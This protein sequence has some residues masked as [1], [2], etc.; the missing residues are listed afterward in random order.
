MVVIGGTRFGARAK[1]RNEVEQSGLYAFVILWEKA[2][3]SSH[4]RPLK[5]LRL[6]LVQWNTKYLHVTDRSAKSP[7]TVTSTV[8]ATLVEGF[9]F[10]KATP[11]S[12]SV[13]GNLLSMDS[14]PS[15]TVIVPLADTGFVL[16]LIVISPS[17][18]PD[19]NH[20]YS[21]PSF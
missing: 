5:T 8:L 15:F 19:R 1:I 16:S 7:F 11:Y 18:A 13:I 6:D 14:L 17:L 20:W 21:S 2:T 3:R 9:P 12:A 4:K 10:W